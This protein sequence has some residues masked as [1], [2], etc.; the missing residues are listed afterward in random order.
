[1]FYKEYRD[2]LMTYL[3]KLKRKTFIKEWERAI[4]Q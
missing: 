4:I 3:D 1:M 2:K